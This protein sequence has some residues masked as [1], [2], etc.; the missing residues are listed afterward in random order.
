MYGFSAASAGMLISSMNGAQPACDFATAADD[1]DDDDEVDNAP[2]N[3]AEEVVIDT[4][5]L[6]QYMAL[7]ES[8]LSDGNFTVLSQTSDR[9]GFEEKWLFPTRI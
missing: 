3:G 9:D 7:V 6:D 5:Q 8:L 4:A 2:A 1:D